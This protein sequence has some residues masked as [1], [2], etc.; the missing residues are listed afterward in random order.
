MRGYH[1]WKT[2]GVSALSSSLGP[3]LLQNCSLWASPTSVVLPTSPSHEA[4]QSVPVL[5]PGREAACR[6]LA[7]GRPLTRWVLL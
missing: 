3:T 6:P 4:K 2:L 1:W 7:G 5:P